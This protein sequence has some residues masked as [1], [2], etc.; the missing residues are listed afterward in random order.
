MTSNGIRLFFGP[1]VYGSYGTSSGARPVGLIHVRLPP[2]NLVHPDEHTVSQRPTTTIYGAPTSN[3]QQTKRP[4]VVSKLSNA[5]YFNGLTLATQAG[6]T[7]EA[8]YIMCLAPDLTHIGNL[9][10][11]NVPSQVPQPQYASAYSNNAP[12]SNRPSLVE[13]GTLESVSGNA[14]MVASLPHQSL[15]LPAN[16]PAPSAINELATEFSEPTAQFLVLTNS[17]LT[18]LVKRRAI[19]YLKAVL[20]ELQSGGNVQPIIDFRDR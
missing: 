20:E 11:V 5:C 8:D 12:A 19:D 3:S 18:F 17:G 14:C 4:Y 2:T 9:G 7:D 1:T 16:T 13:A 6:D 10:Q 15:V